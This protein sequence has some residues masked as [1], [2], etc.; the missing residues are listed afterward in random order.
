MRKV[1]T[2]SSRFPLFAVL[3]G[4]LV[5]PAAVSSRAV[6]APPP[7]PRV[8]IMPGYPNAPHCDPSEK[9]PVRPGVPVIVWG[10]ANGG[11]GT[12]VGLPYVISFSANPNVSV[13]PVAPPLNG[14]ITNDRYI[15][16]EVTFNLLSG[17]T[18]ECITAKLQVTFPGPVTLSKT[19]EIV[20]IAPTDPSSTAPLDN[21][22]INVDIAIEDGLRALYLMQASNGSW[23]STNGGVQYTCAS[24]GFALWAFENKGH[25]R[26]NPQGDD[27]YAEF[28]ERGLEF[29]MSGAI[30][31]GT[32]AANADTIR[33]A[34]ANG[35]SDLN[36]NARS[37]HLCPPGSYTAWYPPPIAAAAIIASLE[38]S[39]VVQTGPF[40]GTTFQTVLED[41]IDWI[42]T[43][44]N[45]VS[46]SG[47]RGGWTYG[48]N[49]AG[50]DMSISSW[51]YL[52][53]EGMQFLAPCAT[54]GGG[55][56]QIPCWIKQEAEYA[57]VYHQNNA[58]GPQP[59]GYSNAS[60][61]YSASEGVAT[62]AGGLSGLALVQTVNCPA[63][64]QIIGMAPPPLNTITAK[65]NAALS[66][67]GVAWNNT[68]N[69]NFLGYGNR[70]NFYVMWTTARALRITAKALFL[71]AGQK[72]ILSHGGVD[73]DWETGE[74][75][76]AAVGQG[77]VP[78]PGNPREGYF[79]FLVRT[80]DT[81]SGP[82]LRGRWNLGTY[83]SGFDGSPSMETSLGVLVLIQSVFGPE[84]QVNC[85]DDI[86][87]KCQ[88]SNGAIVNYNVT[89]SGCPAG[90]TLVC[91][92]PSGS[93]FPI[94]T[95]TVQCYAQYPCGNKRSLPCCFEVTVE[96]PCPCIE[97]K[98]TRIDCGK[99]T[100]EY[101]YTFSVT[102]LSGVP[103][104]R[105]KL[106]PCDMD[107]DFLPD[108]TMT[109][110]IFNFGTPIPNG[111]TTSISVTIS[112]S[113]PKKPACFEIWAFDKEFKRCCVLKHCVK[114]PDCCV[115]IIDQKIE[116]DPVA[117]GQYIWTFK[118]K[119]QAPYT[120][121]RF[122]IWPPG[123][124]TMT[125]TSFIL[126]PIPTGGT[127]GPLS[128]S[129][130]GALPGT[131]CFDVSI[132]K[133]AT[134]ECCY[135]TICLTLPDCNPCKVEDRCE[136]TQAIK[137]CREGDQLRGVI[138][139]T[140]CNYCS[141]HPVEFKFSLDGITDA[142]CPIKYLS[143]ANFSPSSGVTFPVA[144][145][146]CV[147]IPIT[148]TTNFGQ[149]PAGQIACFKATV[150]NLQTGDTFCCTGKAK[151]P[152]PNSFKIVADPKDPIDVPKGRTALVVFEVRNEGSARASL[153]YELNTHLPGLTGSG[154][155]SLNGLPPGEPVRRTISVDPGA[156][157]QVGA[158][159][160]FRIHSPLGVENVYFLADDGN[161]A[162]EALAAVSVRS[163][164]ADDCN[165]NG[166]PDDV[167]ISLCT[168]LDLNQNGIPDEC[169]GLVPLVAG[170]SFRRGDANSDGIVNV[171]DP[172]A[173][174][175]FL[176]SGLSEIACADAADANDQ[177]AIEIGDAVKILNYLFLGGHEPP[178]PGP[179]ECGIDP[180][181]DGMIC[182]KSSLCD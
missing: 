22:D 43:A 1:C 44:Q 76:I 77:N 57:L 112:G 172:V 17:S 52:A 145:G 47:P 13:V 168:S 133:S 164:S 72:V 65:R 176:F 174:L 71:P 16:E 148:I 78:A 27:I 32:V 140:I 110:D 82:T 179:E 167:D 25:L 132:H 136:L 81:S 68:V 33:G 99:T 92:P 178:V 91:N 95:T 36:S 142:S 93:L 103:V 154:A 39:Y 67:I 135:E 141:D 173:I 86:T 63:P 49:A 130:S 54:G 34:T 61:L 73:F 100:G 90:T 40:A 64:G 6:A 151:S 126:P 74:T 124:V 152:S 5:L 58:A 116:C 138:K 98:D 8:G 89:A 113:D 149:F 111:G 94:G 37:I 84:C 46:A 48:A 159:V 143:P 29:I 128:V 88:G 7:N 96:E 109:P 15:F 4:A 3:V 2:L 153:A 147:T 121:D 162:L 129:I 107:G 42:G 156:V 106:L 123:G 105:I 41:V 182:A 161:K 139:L 170:E 69:S 181:Q 23:P 53:L 11:N 85:P 117:P 75:F 50:S 114:L 157:T 24:T 108:F 55:G 31:S 10:N 163:V 26:S 18:K 12:A 62:T 175:S 51:Y 134:D 21:L 169:E 160:S 120:I 60:P 56:L 101:T 131:I 102:N 115:E 158:E 97:V 150:T 127:S 104:S 118:I 70:G 30:S 125:P 165:G 166:V 59:F 19:V 66:H 20:I 146:E 122:F 80:Q 83:I 9:R 79:P 155:V 14:N 171:S 119:N 180:T 137:L 28:V 38:P 144:K 35:V 87:V 45:S 177:G